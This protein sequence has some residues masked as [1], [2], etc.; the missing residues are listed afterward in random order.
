MATQ[1]HSMQANINAKTEHISNDNKYYV[2]SKNTL[3]VA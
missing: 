1:K 2:N 3:L